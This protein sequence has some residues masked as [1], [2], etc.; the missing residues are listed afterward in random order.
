MKN[1]GNQD[2]DDYKN[3]DPN[4]V[5]NNYNQNPKLGQPDDP[6]FNNKDAVI[7]KSLVK[8]VTTGFL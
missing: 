5:D 4:N 8:I 3:N 7:H 1:D 6:D 2:T